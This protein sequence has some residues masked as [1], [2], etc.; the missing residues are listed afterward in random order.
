[1]KHEND[2]LATPLYLKEDDST[3]W[4]ESESVFYYLTKSGFFICRNNPFFQSAVP[5][6]RWP[7]ELATQESFLHVRYPRIP[8]RQ[9]ELAVGFFARVADLAG[10]EAGVLIVWDSVAKRVSLV[11]PP[12]VATVYRARDGYTSPIGLHYDVPSDL[13]EGASVIGDIHSHVDHA[14]YSSATDQDDEVYRPGL[15]LVVGRIH[16]EPPEFHCEAVVDGV[17]FRVAI[18]L[19]INGYRQR[20]PDFPESWLEKVRVETSSDSAGGA[21]SGAASAYPYDREARS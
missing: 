14:A 17:R 2:R 9:L 20:R 8:R 7:S 4:P 15:H 5:A 13:P 12:Q 11:A 1:M 21:R 3:P 16:R 6:R 19:V 18:D 10:A